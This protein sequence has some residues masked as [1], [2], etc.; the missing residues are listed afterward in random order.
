MDVHMRIVIINLFYRILIMINI[1]QNG[2]DGFGHQLHGLISIMAL[3]GVNQY[4]FDAIAFTQKVFTFEHISKT[5]SLELA[6]YLTEVAQSFAIFHQMNVKKYKEIMHAHEVYLI[7]EKYSSEVLYS[8]DNCYY[9]DRIPISLREKLQVKDNFSTLNQ[10][11]LNKKISSKNSEPTIVIHIRLG[12]AMHTPRKNSLLK[13]KADVINC[14]PKLKNK[15]PNHL[16]IIHTDGE[17]PEI[18]KVLKQQQSDYQINSK[19]TPI[20]DVM[21]DMIYANVFICGNS[22]LSKACVFLNTAG[23]D[24]YVHEDNKHSLPDNVQKISS[25]K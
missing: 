13:F 18:E 8:L 15:Y 25:I 19:N 22:S 12:D 16:F 24:I 1:I 20:L 21:S 11:F 4:Y 2:T 9:L 17:I 6:E 7:P 5:E 10:F 14:L 3:H 23:R